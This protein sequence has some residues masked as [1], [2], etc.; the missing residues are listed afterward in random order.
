MRFLFKVD[1]FTY[2]VAKLA[3][4]MFAQELHRKLVEDGVPII[5]V[6]LNPGGVYTESSDIFAIAGPL[7]RKTMMT[8]SDGAKNSAFAAAAPVVRQNQEWFGGNYLDPVGK[9]SDFH[10]EVKN[11]ALVEGLWK[12]TQDAA[13][14]HLRGLGLPELS[15]W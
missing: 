9:V 2:S 5:S 13:N 11:Q 3:N 8:P 6:H 15:P 4:A 14:K 12:N 1:M 10:S 7:I